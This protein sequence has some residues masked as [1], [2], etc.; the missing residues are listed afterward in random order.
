[1]NLDGNV[2]NTKQSPSASTFRSSSDQV[3]GPV[4]T[5]LLFCLLE[6]KSLSPFN[7][8]GA[9]E[10]YFPEFCQ[11]RVSPYVL[12]SQEVVMYTGSFTRTT[13]KNDQERLGRCPGTITE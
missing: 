3:E 6:P 11:R 7:Q 1:M 4:H 12:G 9:F 2:P 5:C 13:I 8:S 10:Y